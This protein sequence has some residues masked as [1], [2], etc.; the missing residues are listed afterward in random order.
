MFTNTQKR[1]NVTTTKYPKQEAILSLINRLPS[2]KLPESRRDKFTGAGE[3]SNLDLDEALVAL[4][5]NCMSARFLLDLQGEP[6]VTITTLRDKIQLGKVFLPLW[7]RHHWL[8]GVLDNNVLQI[9]DSSPGV[10]TRE[11]ISLLINLLSFIKEAPI[12]LKW[13]STPRQ[14]KGSVECGLH[15]VINA[16]LHQ[17]LQK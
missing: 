11:D 7:I 17:T 14:P 8:L 15:V 10:A 12:N 4:G 1:K 13:F 16:I 5:V 9:A 2:P 6:D 3:W